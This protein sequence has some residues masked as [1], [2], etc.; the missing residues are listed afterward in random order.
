MIRKHKKKKK[1][2]ELITAAAIAKLS[3]H[4]NIITTS[5]S[6]IRQIRELLS[7]VKQH[8]AALYA[9]V[10]MYTCI[11]NGYDFLDRSRF[12]PVYDIIFVFHDDIRT[13]VHVIF[14]YPHNT[15]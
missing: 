10:M 11:Y 15:R 4:G 1:N 12:S 14:I 3:G 5:S 9:L 2:S 6:R 8:N 13:Y 7:D